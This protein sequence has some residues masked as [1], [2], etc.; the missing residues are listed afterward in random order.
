MK[1]LPDCKN[2]ISLCICKALLTS[3]YDLNSSDKLHFLI[4]FIESQSKKCSYFDDY[5]TRFTENK[6][7]IVSLVKTEELIDNILGDEK[8][9]RNINKKV[10]RYCRSRDIL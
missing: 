7:P 8:Y 3:Y 6:H 2:C 9:R 1:K 4:K 5:V 10:Y